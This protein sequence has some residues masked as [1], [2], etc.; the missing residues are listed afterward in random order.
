MIEATD[1]LAYAS[2]CISALIGALYALQTSRVSKLENKIEE[3]TR[4]KDQ[5]INDSSNIEKVIKILD[6]LKDSNAEMKTTYKL[7]D[8]HVRHEIANMRVSVNGFGTR[9]GAFEED[10]KN[11]E[12]RL[13]KIEQKLNIE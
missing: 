10:N 11:H 8:S 6:D 2:I 3:L 13:S 7:L 9:L 12:K 4:H 1:I 5:T